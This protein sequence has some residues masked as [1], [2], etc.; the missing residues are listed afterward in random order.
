MHEEASN[1]WLLPF[2]KKSA[3]V[4]EE[5]VAK[6]AFAVNKGSGQQ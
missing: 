6:A 4:C 2:S 3:V 1:N 5:M